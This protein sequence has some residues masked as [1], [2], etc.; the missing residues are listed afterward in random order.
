MGVSG[1]ADHRVTPKPGS[2]FEWVS[3][4]RKPISRLDRLLG[5]AGAVH[6]IRGSRSGL[7]VR[8]GGRPIV[9]V[10]PGSGE[11]WQIESGG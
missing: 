5:V 10:R 9:R 3:G 8:L 1:R 11:S 2:G 4:F 6:G 7:Q